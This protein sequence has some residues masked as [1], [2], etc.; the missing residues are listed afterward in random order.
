MKRLLLIG[1]DSADW[2]LIHPLL[3]KS[4]LPGV[5]NLVEGGAS[6]NLTTLA[7][8]LSPMLWTS[9]GQV[10]QVFRSACGQLLFCSQPSIADEKIKRFVHGF[11][12]KEPA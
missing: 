6:G 11:T 12:I 7:P 5:A 4:Y 10:K 3:D 8:Q 2:K 9:I 1:W